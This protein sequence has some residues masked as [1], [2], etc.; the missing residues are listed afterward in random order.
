MERTKIENLNASL[1]KASRLNR[2]LQMKCYHSSGDLRMLRIIAHH[3][4]DGLTP[5]ILAEKM[6][7][8]LPTVSRK[9]SVLE[10]QELIQRKPSRT[11]RRKTFVFATEKGKEL[12]RE[13]YLRFINRFSTACEKLG[14]DKV[15]QLHS[16]LAELG[17]Y[18]EEEIQQEAG[19]NT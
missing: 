7:I 9:L 3:E 13:D 5:S 4:N 6:E 16:L 1:R 19:E 14:E 11:D 8:A 15:W 2:F 10:K 17:G 12:L 18:L